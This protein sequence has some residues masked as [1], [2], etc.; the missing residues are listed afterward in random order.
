M[1]TLSK[2]IRKAVKTQSNAT[3]TLLDASSSRSELETRCPRAAGNGRGRDR[4]RS[5]MTSK[6]ATKGNGGRPATGSI[7][8]ADPKTKT[9]PI[10][11]RVTKANGGRKIVPLDPGTTSDEAIALSP[12]L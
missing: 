11:V 10:G 3:K 12:I 8:W 2:R 9:Q 6:L 4:R 7:V 5:P 1:Q